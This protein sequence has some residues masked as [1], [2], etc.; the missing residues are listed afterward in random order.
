V[1]RGG[2]GRGPA[3]AGAWIVRPRA[4]PAARLRLFCFPYAGGG[5]AIYREWPALLPADVEVCAVQPPGREG[6]LA[7][8]PHAD[9]HDLASA[10]YDA[11]LAELDRPFAFFGHSNG[12]LMAFELTRTLRRRGGP[13]PRRLFA[14]GRAA[15]QLPPVTDP[16]HDLPADAFRDQLR[17]LSGTPE[18]VLEHPEL[19]ELLLPL[20][21]A[22]FA[23][24]ETYRYDP[25]PPLGVPITALGG[26]DDPF[27]SRERVAAWEAQTESGFRLCMLPGGHF[28]VNTHRDAVVRETAAGLAGTGA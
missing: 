14:S 9:M 13:L 10:L 7:E 20:L 15:P 6:R 16:L 4:N 2:A 18:E 25:E 23:L 22:D 11:V 3:S 19:F 27:V 17:L 24:D 26:L 12:A 5:A 21:R 8:V 28:F 1:S